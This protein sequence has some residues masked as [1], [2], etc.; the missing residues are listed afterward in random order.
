M[1]KREVSFLVQPQQFHVLL[2]PGIGYL[3]PRP[4]A[5]PGRGMPVTGFPEV[6]LLG[7]QHPVRGASTRIST[8]GRSDSCSK[9]LN[10]PVLGRGVV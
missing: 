3:K 4:A 1:I 5:L 8:R 9:L 2:P 6:L 7:G 10:W